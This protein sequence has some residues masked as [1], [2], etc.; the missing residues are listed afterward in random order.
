[1]DVVAFEIEDSQVL[2]KRYVEQVINLVEGDIQF[3]QLQKGLN[4]LHFSYFASGHVKYAHVPK[5]SADISE[6]SDH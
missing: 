5:R 2:Q 6:A 1:M 3:F 4:A